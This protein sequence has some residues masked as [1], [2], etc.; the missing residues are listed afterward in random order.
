LTGIT[1]PPKS[2][3]RNSANDPVFLAR[4]AKAQTFISFLYAKG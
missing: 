4:F 3:S 1:T 2:F